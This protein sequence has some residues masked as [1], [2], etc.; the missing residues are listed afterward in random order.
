MKTGHVAP[1]IWHLK[2]GGTLIAT[3]HA[4][5]F[6]FPWT[7]G[8]LVDSPGFERFRTYFSDDEQWP[9]AREFEDLCAEIQRS[10]RFCIANPATGEHFGDVCLHHDGDH[11]WFR[12]S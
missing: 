12:Y 7:H 5:A 10:G 6:E 11:V 9:D 8:R 4:T 2:L 3:L 1:V